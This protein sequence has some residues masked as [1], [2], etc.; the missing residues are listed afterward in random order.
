MSVQNF[1][2]AFL[3]NQKLENLAIDWDDLVK[4]A[5]SEL[6]RLAQDDQNF[7][8]AIKSSPDDFGYDY[9]YLD[10]ELV[11]KHLTLKDLTINSK[12]ALDYYHEV[13]SS[14]DHKR[15]LAVNQREYYNKQIERALRKYPVPSSHINA[16]NICWALINL[17]VYQEFVQADEQTLLEVGEYA[18]QLDSMSTI[19]ND[20][21][22]EASDAVRNLHDQY[23][24]LIGQTKQ[25]DDLL[26]QMSKKPDGKIVHL[27]NNGENKLIL[28]NKQGLSYL[29]AYAVWNDSKTPSLEP[30]RK[31]AKQMLDYGVPSGDDKQD[32]VIDIYSAIKTLVRGYQTSSNKSV[33]NL[34]QDHRPSGYY[35]L[36]VNDKDLVQND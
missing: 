11:I 17:P 23:A 1:K 6:M 18:D 3:I 14:L 20:D 4:K 30:L 25:F 28:L 33:Q 24:L 10:N 19:F 22:F 7:V 32:S 16:D 8:K 12:N 9:A 27:F 35:R 15:E 13:Q 36:F 29:L 2:Y 26:H 21:Q 34:I 5:S 31:W